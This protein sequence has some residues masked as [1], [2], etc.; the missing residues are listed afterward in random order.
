MLLTNYAAGAKN[1]ITIKR[2][3]NRAKLLTRRC[4]RL[5]CLVR[6]RSEHHT[7]KFNRRPE[8]YS[9]LKSGITELAGVKSAA[10][11]LFQRVKRV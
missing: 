7:F 1:I 4:G 8:Y 3:Q 6:F 5:G 9:Y 2:G 11:W 10:H